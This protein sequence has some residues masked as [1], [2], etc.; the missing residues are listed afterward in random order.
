MYACRT[1]LGY[2]P[3]KWKITV[4]YISRDGEEVAVEFEVMASSCMLALEAMHEGLLAEHLGD[5]ELD[6]YECASYK[7]KVDRV[8]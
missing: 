1:P 8:V 6:A 2:E 3:C 7:V 4:E 5:R